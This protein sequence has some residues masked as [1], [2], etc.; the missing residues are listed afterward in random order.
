MVQYL[1]TLGGIVLLYLGLKK[2]VDWRVEAKLEEMINT[3]Y[4]DKEK[5][6]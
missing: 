6:A 3:L 2:F 5:S 4:P 1:A